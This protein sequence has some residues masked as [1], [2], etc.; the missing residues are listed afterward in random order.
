MWGPETDWEPFPGG[1][2][3]CTVGL[4]RA[5]ADGCHWI[6]KRLR[7]PGPDDDPELSAPDRPGYW[8][9]E[10]DVAMTIGRTTG[11]V[12]PEVRR[13]DEDEDGCTVWTRE[14]AREPMAAP[15]VAGA[16]GRFASAGLPDSVRPVRHLLGHRV[17]RAASRGGWPTLAGT[18]V[19]SLTEALWA[20]R[21]ALLDRFEA[22]AEVPAHGD[23][24]PANLLARQGDDVLTVD[25]GLLGFAPA[26]A[27]LGYFALSCRESFEVLL[28][29]YLS[30]LTTAGM[31]AR[32][33]DV[34]YAARLTAVYTVVARAEWA[35]A[36][37]AG[38]PG[39]L[40]AKYRHPA[41]APHLRSLQRQLPQIEELLSAQD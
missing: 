13:V 34:S 5:R 24:V 3:A 28:S 4:W 19:A 30:G 31:S 29:S 15:F 8:R 1:G 27:D 36:R 23:V 39:A 38:S 22:I 20:R 32:P 21:G 16:L 9:R 25:W 41:V 2:G 17:G 12:A 10:A 11:L 26:G 18:M 33:E 37:V 14:H 40:D 6:V 35:L 7:T